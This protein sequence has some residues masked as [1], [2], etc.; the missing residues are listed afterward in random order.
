MERESGALVPG[1]VSVV[2][3]V[4][5]GARQL[6]RFLDSV[7]KQ[8]YDQIE[9]IVADDGS[10]DNT[11]AVAESY[12]AQFEKRGYSLRVVRGA[13]KNASA[14]INLGLPFVTG[15]YL[16]WPDS[17]DV[18]APESVERRVAFLR[19]HPEYRCVRALPYYFDEKTGGPTAEAQEKTGDLSKENLFWDILEGRSFVCCGCYMLQSACFFEI[20][21]QRRIPESNAGQ[22]FQMLLP[23]LY[24]HRCPTI[25]EELYG[26][27]V[28][29]GSHS[30]AK[31]SQA[32]EEER[33]QAFEV[34]VDEI[35]AVCG[36]GEEEKARV[37]RWKLLRRYQ[38]SL[39]Y[40]QKRRAFQALRQ[41]RRWGGLP[42]GRVVKDTVWL[43]FFEN[44]AGKR[45][46]RFYRR[47]RAG[48]GK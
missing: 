20:Y 13:H 27:C 24:R 10:Q 7:L 8:S 4:F 41:L 3:P 39:R 44:R 22:N 32:Q 35:A 37:L 16:I 9:M 14:A 47:L 46:Y 21:P 1:R 17:D 2:T 45:L 43:C 31:R 38:L 26:V 34:L 19:A 28:R 12:R 11:Q 25:R 30:R 5:N 40:G 6:P 42:F 29:E 36:L 23:F 48:R 18:L 33:Y 15:E